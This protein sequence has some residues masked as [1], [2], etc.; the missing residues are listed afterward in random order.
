[1]RARYAVLLHVGEKGY[2]LNGLTQTLKNTNIL[3]VQALILP[4]RLTPNLKTTFFV[5]RA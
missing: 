3:H 2:G 4:A 1:M 5:Y